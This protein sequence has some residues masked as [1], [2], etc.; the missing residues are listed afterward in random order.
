MFIITPYQKLIAIKFVLYSFPNCC[1]YCVGASPARGGLKC[2]NIRRS[3]IPFAT[4]GKLAGSFSEVNA[5]H[6]VSI[7]IYL[8][9]ERAHESLN[10]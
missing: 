7:F 8:I 3:L 6:A 4:S 10:R 9:C 2:V 1:H 5:L